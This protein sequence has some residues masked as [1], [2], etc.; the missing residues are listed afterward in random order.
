MFKGLQF[1]VKHVSK[2]T[3]AGCYRPEC[4]AVANGT[5]GGL[6]GIWSHVWLKRKLRGKFMTVYYQFCEAVHSLF[7]SRY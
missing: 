3:F 4:L 1:K 6:S 2:L 7:C 5:V